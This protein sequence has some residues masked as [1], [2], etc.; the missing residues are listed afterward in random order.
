MTRWIIFKVW[1]QY[2]LPSYLGY[3]TKTSEFWIGYLCGVISIYMGNLL[4]TS[5]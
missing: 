3:M 5:L 4:W 1:V 2:Q